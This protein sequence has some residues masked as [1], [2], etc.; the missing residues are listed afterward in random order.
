MNINQI[1]KSDLIVPQIEIQSNLD[2]DNIGDIKKISK[3]QK[4]KQRVK[5]LI[6]NSTSHGLPH[7]LRSDILIIKI[8]WICFFLICFTLSIYFKSL[9][10]YL[11]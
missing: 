4:I 3:S 6:I 8:M 9:L 10:F 2:P 11:E 5:Q 7:L 1:P